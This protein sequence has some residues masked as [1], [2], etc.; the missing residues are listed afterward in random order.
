MKVIALCNSDGE[1]ASLASMRDGGPPVSFPNS[2]PRQQQI[3]IEAEGLTEEMSSSE[4]I[5][6]LIEIRDRQRVKIS[7]RK[8]VPK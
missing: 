7:E 4:V 3:V 2:D 8:F 5:T 1:I 6:R